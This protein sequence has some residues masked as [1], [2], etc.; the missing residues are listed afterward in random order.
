MKKLFPILLLWIT[1]ILLMALI[2]ILPGCSSSKDVHKTQTST[3]SSY[4][5]ELEEQNKV[6]SMENERLS[7]EVRELQF[8]EVKFDTIY[9]AGDT[10]VNTIVITK[11]GE[12]KAAGNIVSATVSKNVFTKIVKEKERIIDSLKQVKG[13]ETVKYITKT[14]YKEK[15]KKTSFMGS[16]WIWLLIGLIAGLYLG[17]RLR[18][19]MN[20]IDNIK[21]NSMKNLIVVILCSLLLA[22]CGSKEPSNKISKTEVKQIGWKIVDKFTD[23]VPMM[24]TV[25]STEPTAGQANHFASQRKDHGLWI[26][27]G[28]TLGLLTIF[29]FAGITDNIRW[30]PSF[31]SLAKGMGSFTLIVLTAMSFTWQVMNVRWRNTHKI[32]KSH[33][34]YLMKRDGSIKAFWDSL[35]NGCHIVGGKYDCWD[36]DNK[37][38]K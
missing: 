1:G 13:K 17:W 35:N 16:L 34:D 8:A 26:G 7:A 2:F 14:E 15:H 37:R 12:V 22:S 9:R 18:K 33:Y 4:T 5:K 21:P 28:I 36:K 38:V 24:D 31:S 27:I 19:F 3:D 23:P 29:W 30:F 10:V 25:Y 11:E 32:S 20:Q 6:L